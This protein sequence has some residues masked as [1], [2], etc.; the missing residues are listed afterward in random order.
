[1][2]FGGTV[3]GILSMNDILL[4]AGEGKDVD[5]ADVIG[6]LQAICEHHHPMPQIVAA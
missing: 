2:G 6:T 5:T 4:E 3:L 1:M